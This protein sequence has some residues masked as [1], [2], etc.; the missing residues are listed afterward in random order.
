MELIKVGQQ[1][2]VE[3][4]IRMPHNVVG[5]LKYKELKLKPV[6]VLAYSLMLNRLSLSIDRPHEFSKNGVFY[7]V[8]EQKELAADLGLSNRG[9]INTLQRLEEVGL[10]SVE[11]QGKMLPNLYMFYDIFDLSTESLCEKISPVCK[12]CTQEVQKCHCIKN[13]IIKTDGIKRYITLTSDDNKGS[14]VRFMKLYNDMYRLHKQKEHPA[15]EYSQLQEL[16][17]KLDALI[18]RYQ[19]TD[20]DLH[21]IIELHF[22]ELPSDNDG[23]LQYLL[24]G[25]DTQSVFIRHL[26][27]LGI[28]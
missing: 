7:I 3:K 8:Y 28:V 2:K 18:D 4:F 21:D 12:K 25:N 19:L 22:N 5:L 11:R 17:N 13:D 10:I 20:T 14:Q 23:K 24:S 1:L 9:I 15:I 26:N 16:H 6:D 27:V